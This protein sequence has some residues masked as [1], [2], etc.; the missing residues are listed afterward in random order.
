MTKINPAKI[1]VTCKCGEPITRTL[2]AQVMASGR[3]YD[4]D[5]L[6]RISQRG[7]EARRAKKLSVESNKTYEN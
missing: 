7:V 6:R 2:A 4:H 3:T 1:S 5:H